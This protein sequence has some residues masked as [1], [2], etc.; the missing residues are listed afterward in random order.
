VNA[1]KV[2]AVVKRWAPR[3]AAVTIGVVVGATLL[4]LGI[5][6]AVDLGATRGDLIVM[7]SGVLAVAAANI[8]WWWYRDR[9]Q[10]AKARDADW[11][12]AAWSGRAAEHRAYIAELERQNT[13]LTAE[14]EQLR[15]SATTA[16]LTKRMGE[17]P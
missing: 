1:A 10:A 11:L 6:T 9:D 14:V 16:H 4:I 3:V 7:V 17:T 5:R 12:A 15:R 8:F 13:G 2:R